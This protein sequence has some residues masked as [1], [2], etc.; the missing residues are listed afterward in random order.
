MGVVSC[1]L[2]FAVFTLQSTGLART[3]C[4]D[5][6]IRF[7]EVKLPDSV[8]FPI[9]YFEDDAQSGGAKRLQH[10]CV[11]SGAEGVRGVRPL[12]VTKK[13][14]QKHVMLGLIEG[15]YH[16]LRFNQGAQQDSGTI[17][18]QQA[19]PCFSPHQLEPALL[20]HEEECKANKPTRIKMPKPGRKDLFISFKEWRYTS[21]RPS[22]S[23]QT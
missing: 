14:K 15:E 23:T 7:R 17:Q 10:K 21:L 9:Q 20:K 19:P 12:Y 8:K 5:L 18:A 6:E 4:T 13:K 2:F 16:E 3:S 11:P 1:G 22:R